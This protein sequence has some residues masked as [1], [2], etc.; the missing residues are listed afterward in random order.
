[1][2]R[3]SASEASRPSGG[4][5]LLEL[6]LVL[7]VFALAGLLV[8]PDLQ[9]LMQRTSTEADLRRVVSFLDDVRSRAVAGGRI[10]KVV[11]DDEG[12]RLVALVRGGEETIV[13]R[14]LPENL[15]LL[16]MKPEELLYFPQGN[17]SGGVLTFAAEDGDSRSRIEIGSFTGLS[18]TV[19][20]ER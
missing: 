18:R 10:L 9:P 14:R 19:E 2:K 15:R 7:F 20:G 16:G 13:H 3:K 17:A 12:H 5:T 1:M 6:V 11:H 4:F 8:Y